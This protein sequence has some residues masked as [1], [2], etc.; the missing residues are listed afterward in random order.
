MNCL[1]CNH[2]FTDFEPTAKGVEEIYSDDDFFKG[3]AGYDDYTLEKDMRI[4]RVEYY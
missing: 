4:K 3:G 1:N 2:V